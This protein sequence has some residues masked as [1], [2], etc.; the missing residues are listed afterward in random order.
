MTDDSFVKE[1]I[2]E[3]DY[4][5]ND[6]L[7][8]V[9]VVTVKNK[10]TKEIL[11]LLCKQVP[12]EQYEL[13][14]LKRVRKKKNENDLVEIVICPVTSYNKLESSVRAYC[15]Q[16]SK[17][18]VSVAK[19]QPITKAEFKEWGQYW[20]VNYHPSED[21]RNQEK[22][23]TAEELQHIARLCKELET[24]NTLLA[25]G[26]N[27]VLSCHG[28]LLVNSTTNQTVVSS[29]IAYDH[30]ESQYGRDAVVAH[31]LL[32][33]T[34]ICINHLAGFV[35]G[36]LTHDEGSLPADQY[37]CTGMDLYLYQEP[38]LMSA[39]ALVHSR[40]RR[41]YFIQADVVEGASLSGNGHIHQLQALN[42]HY[43]VFKIDPNQLRHADSARS[44][45]TG[46]TI[47]R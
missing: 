40:I 4:D 9:F 38:D 28:A 42:H 33:P 34:M 43:R 12:L 27:D 37:L 24:V 39:M 21:E 29:K 10:S 19:Y 11:D 1:I 2:I 32:T 16:F 30:V 17:E 31:P 5:T 41:V 8:D 15:D 20:P 18:T 3:R 35:S 47:N 6:V 45:T 22:G 36:T 26:T 13:L 25:A 46:S 23:L 44:F 14:H 7:V